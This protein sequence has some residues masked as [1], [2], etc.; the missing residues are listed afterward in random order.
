MY[1]NQ[2]TEEG[3]WGG[4]G[5]LYI[6]L[7]K[8][9]RIKKGCSGKKKQQHLTWPC[10]ACLANGD[11]RWGEELEWMREKKGGQGCEGLK[12]E[13]SERQKGSH[14]N[15]WQHWQRWRTD[16]VPRLQ[17]LDGP[18]FDPKHREVNTTQSHVSVYMCVCVHVSV[19][20]LYCNYALD[21]WFS[22][23]KD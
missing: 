23:K 5:T 16:V 2:W 1:S 19:Y 18:S 7:K 15:T 10:A 14:H 11:M 6:F 12:D 17:W 21:R 4:K 20:L 8:E 13:E 3:E 22:K 9:K